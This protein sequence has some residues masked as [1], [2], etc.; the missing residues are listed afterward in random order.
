MDERCFCASS[1]YGLCICDLLVLICLCELC[2]N[3]TFIY[4]CVCVCFL[5]RMYFLLCGWVT[6]NLILNNTEEMLVFLT[7]QR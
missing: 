5:F 6:W 3:N 7:L 2:M 1:M 4:M